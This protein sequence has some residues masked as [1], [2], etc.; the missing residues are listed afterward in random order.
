MFFLRIDSNIDSTA[1]V[2]ATIYYIAS[3]AAGIASPFHHSQYETALLQF[4]E[5]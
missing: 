2:S 5:T 1:N 4:V 3:S